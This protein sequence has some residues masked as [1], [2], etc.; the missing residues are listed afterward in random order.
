[1]RQV[2]PP[3]KWANFVLGS[4]G[5]ETD[6]ANEIMSAMKEEEATGRPKLGTW[7]GIHSLK[8]CRHHPSLLILGSTLMFVVINGIPS[9]SNGTM[10]IVGNSQVG[11]QPPKLPVFSHLPPNI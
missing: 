11:T 10:V 2:A 3:M 4:L 6:L 9:P 8:V 5:I 1:M 7:D